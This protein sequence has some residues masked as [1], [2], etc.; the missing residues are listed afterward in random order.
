M[1]I[2]F[3]FLISV[4]WVKGMII[5]IMPLREKRLPL[6]INFLYIHEES[7]KEY[8]FVALATI[9]PGRW[10]FYA[11]GDQDSVRFFDFQAEKDTIVLSSNRIPEFIL[12]WRDFRRLYYNPSLPPDSVYREGEMEVKVYQD[13]KYYFNKDTL[14]RIFLPTAMLR[15]ER[16]VRYKKII[17]PTFAKCRSSFFRSFDAIIN[18]F[19]EEKVNKNIFQYRKPEFKSISKIIPK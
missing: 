16:F 15:I 14:K 1:T 10:L 6:R 19:K 8:K 9:S 13:T 5:P 4:L 3:N 12:R 7:K 18:E 2:L 11:V 17:I